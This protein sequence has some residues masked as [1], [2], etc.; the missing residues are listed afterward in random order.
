VLLL[1]AIVSPIIAR[2]DSGFD[3]SYDSGGSD[4]LYTTNGS[5]SHKETIFVE[6]IFLVLF[7]TYFIFLSVLYA[8][9]K[10]DK[11]KIVLFLILFRLIIITLIIFVSSNFIYTDIVITFISGLIFLLIGSKNDSKE[12][13]EK[14][15]FNDIST[16]KLKEYEIENKEE[17]KKELFNKYIDIQEAWMNFDYDKLITLLSDSLFNM[18]KEQL[19]ALKLKNKKNIMNDFEYIDS[20]IIDVTQEN[21]I[22]SLKLYL[23]V[24]MYDYI[25]NKNN[26][27][28][29]GN[30]N[31]KVNVHYEIVFEKSIN[32]SVNKCPNCGSEIINNESNMCHYCNNAIINK[33]KDFV[34]SKKTNI[35]QS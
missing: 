22:L 32:E 28:I 34:M 9:K 8:L 5:S 31:K 3:V 26:K 10:Y 2:A 29:R 33:S 21:G 19:E 18:Y 17:L 4:S 25:V 11:K 6:K 12:L 15:K 14:L 13:N 35:N 16:E 23:N 1:F 7:D 30:K 24:K 20:K 27:V